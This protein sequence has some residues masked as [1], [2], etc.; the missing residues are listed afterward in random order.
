MNY[1]LEGLL[2]ATHCS[3]K[4]PIPTSEATTPKMTATRI[5]GVMVLANLYATRVKLLGRNRLGVV[6]YLLRTMFAKTDRIR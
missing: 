3:H 5:S 6:R 1:E 2:T 4:V